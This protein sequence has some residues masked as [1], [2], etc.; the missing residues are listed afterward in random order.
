MSI[1]NRVTCGRCLKMKKEK[2]N[3]KA[4]QKEGAEKAE[5]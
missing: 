4:G 2:T 3:G 1:W 5:G